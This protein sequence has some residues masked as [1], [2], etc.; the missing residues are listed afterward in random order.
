MI[1]RQHPPEVTGAIAMHSFID[2]VL[3]DTDLARQFRDRFKLAIV[4]LMN[5]DGVAAGHWR[6]NVWRC[7]RK[8]RLGAVHPAG[9]AICDEVG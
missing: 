8:P 7:G 9:I 1:G 3:A 6:H 5:P 2:T 4:P